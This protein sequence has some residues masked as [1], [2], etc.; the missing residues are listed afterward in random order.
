MMEHALTMSGWPSGH[1][2][3]SHYTISHIPLYQPPSTSQG[4]EAY[5]S[6]RENTIMI[7]DLHCNRFIL[8][9][10]SDSTQVHVLPAILLCMFISEKKIERN[11][12]IDY[13]ESFRIFLSKY[14]Q[15]H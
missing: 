7:Y 4:L 1:P 5:Q 12:S 2:D 13:L 10:K 6:K 15:E 9:S 11:K 3:R 14:S 8:Y